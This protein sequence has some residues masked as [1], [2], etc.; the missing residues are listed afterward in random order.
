VELTIDERGDVVDAKL[1]RGVPLL[2]EA[3]LEAVRQWKYSPTLLNE[4]PVP[5]IMT[6]TVTFSLRG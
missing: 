3:A 4:V 2:N 6:A 5:L 1:L